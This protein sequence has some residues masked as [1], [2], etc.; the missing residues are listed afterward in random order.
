MGIYLFNFL[1]FLFS[2]PIGRFIVHRL[3][4]VYLV[5]I[6]SNLYNKPVNRQS[7][8]LKLTIN[9]NKPINR[10]LVN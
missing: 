5:K 3:S 7:V 10:L 4:T 1:N 8:K 9:Y 6:D 2:K